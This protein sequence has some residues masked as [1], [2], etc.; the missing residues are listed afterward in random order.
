MDHKS[1]LEICFS[2]V[3]YIF[4]MI[5]L[6]YIYPLRD[7]YLISRVGQAEI[8]ISQSESIIYERAKFLIPDRAVR[9]FKS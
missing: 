6:P 5:S 9:C 1:Y 4:M 8:I 3:K 7:S 2:L